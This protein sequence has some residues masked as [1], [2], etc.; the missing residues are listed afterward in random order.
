MIWIGLYLS[1]Q[2]IYWQMRA[3]AGCDKFFFTHQILNLPARTL[4]ARVGLDRRF[5]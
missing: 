5:F 2:S 4:G 3:T 1:G